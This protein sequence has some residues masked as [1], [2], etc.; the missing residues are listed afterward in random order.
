MYQV[1]TCLVHGFN[2]K[3][4]NLM[5]IILQQGYAKMLENPFIH[6]FVW[7]VLFDVASGFTKALFFKKDGDSTKGLLGLVKHF[8]VL[9]MVLSLYPYFEVIGL[10]WEGFALLLG[11]ILMYAI[12]I[13]E[14]LGAIGIDIPPFLKDRLIKLKDANDKGELK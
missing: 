4:K 10:S 13:V 2:R 11:F 12:S 14:N 1:I 7:S 5:L 9:C 3:E 6:V 8:L